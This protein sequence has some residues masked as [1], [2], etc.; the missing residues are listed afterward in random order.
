MEYKNVTKLV[1]EIKKI[2]AFQS[3][4]LTESLT[5][6]KEE[7]LVAFNNYIEYFLSSGITMEYLAVSYNVAVKDISKEQ[8]YFKRHKKYRYSKLNEVDEAVY[9]NKEYMDNYMYGLAISYFLWPNHRLM[10]QWFNEKLPKNQKGTYFEVGPG[11]GYFFLSAM[12]LSAYNNFEAV[13]IS[14]ASKDLTESIVKSSFFGNF[15]NYKISNAD[16]LNFEYHK[17]Y[18]AIVVGEV[19]E[20]VEN[21]KVFLERIKEIAQDDA[22]IFVTTAINSPAIDHI[23]LFNSVDAVEKMVLEAGLKVKEKLVLPYMNHTVEEALEYLLPINIALILE[24]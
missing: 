18:D 8:I 7:E 19:L 2:N 4:F 6:I 21:P 17:K 12:K 9:H 11:P 24:K 16:F 10:H 22:Y 15:S 14:E 23:Y 13:D 20:H 1:D 5:S 3:N